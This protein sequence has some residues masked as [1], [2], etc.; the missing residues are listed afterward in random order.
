[1]IASADLQAVGWC[2][3]ALAAWPLADWLGPRLR[4]ALGGRAE[5]VLMWGPWLLGLGPMV[6]AWLSGA[7]PA[8]F[9]GLLGV[10]GWL[11]WLASALLIT[12]MWFGARWFVHNRG[13]WAA[14]YPLDWAVLDE[15]RWALYRAAGWLWVM[16]RGWGLLIGL[17][18]TLVEWAL[19]HHLWRAENRASADTCLTLLR[20]ALSS[21]VFALTGNLWL[22]IIFQVALL[23][24]LASP[25][26]PQGAT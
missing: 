19:R 9:L 4:A 7:V 8:R 23:Q 10:G 11:G 1:M 5:A 16:D 2:A 20:L 15:P 6:L 24:L 22:T 3:L 25:A 26:E 13:P 17:G 18:L 12:G 14:A 21:L